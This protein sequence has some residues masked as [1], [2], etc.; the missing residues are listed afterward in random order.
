MGVWSG[1]GLGGLEVDDQL[2]LYR[3]LHRQVRWLG[4][5]QSFVYM[6]PPVAIGK[7]YGTPELS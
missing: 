3:L 5:L 7:N 2:E 4:I 1:R 6:G